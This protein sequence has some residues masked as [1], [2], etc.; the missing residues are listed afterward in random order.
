M[1]DSGKLRSL[2]LRTMR[3][4][5]K[6]QMPAGSEASVKVF[7]ASRKFYLL[8]L[9]RW[10]FRQLATLIGIVVAVG[11]LQ[12]GGFG[13]AEAVDGFISEDV[14]LGVLKA[15]ELFGI[16]AF[17]AQLPFSLYLVKLDYD[18][19]WYIVTDRSI[20]IREGVWKISEMTLTYANVQEVSIRQGPVQ[21]LLG[22]SDLRVRNAGGGSVAPG[23]GKHG[24][25]EKADSH[26]GFFRGVDNAEEIRDLVLERLKKLRDAGLGDPDQREVDTVEATTSAVTSKLVAAA[27]QLLAEAIALQRI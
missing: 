25:H 14:A 19:R 20:R 4:P 11:A 18:M 23:G 17:L 5:P 8:N 13:I 15:L 16:G 10:G 27:D 21:R 9:V 1:A 22:I 6:P 26:T 3:V 12:T 2:L 7:R 24:D